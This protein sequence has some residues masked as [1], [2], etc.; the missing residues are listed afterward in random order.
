MHGLLHLPAECLKHGP[1]DKFSC[2][3]Y[4]NFLF[5]MK[6]KIQTSR[7]PLQQ[8]CNRIKEQNHAKEARNNENIHLS[9]IHPYIHIHISIYPYI[10]FYISNAQSKN[11]AYTIKQSVLKNMN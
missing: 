3:K 9:N 1:L 10:H 6:Q 5:Q 4:E 7:N 2:F 8:F 11:I